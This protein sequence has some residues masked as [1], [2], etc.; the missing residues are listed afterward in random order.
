MN[1]LTCL[2]MLTNLQTLVY[3]PSGFNFEYVQNEPAHVDYG[4]HVFKLNNHLIKFRVAKITP[5]KLGCFVALWKRDHNGTSIPY[6]AADPF[7]F[8]IIHTVSNKQCGQFIF[9]K[10]ILLKNDVLSLH[11][12]GGKRGFRLYTA[13]DKPESNQAKRTQKWQLPYFHPLLEDNVTCLPSSLF[14][15]MST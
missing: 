1:L 15:T 10:K 3:E 9:P 5:I 8:Y 14:D 7:D 12:K 11:D 2:E 4:A 6:D 13:W